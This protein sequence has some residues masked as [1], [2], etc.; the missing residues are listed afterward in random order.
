MVVLIIV[1]CNGDRLSIPNIVLLI[2]DILIWLFYILPP[3]FKYVMVLSIIGI[4]DDYLVM[5][6]LLSF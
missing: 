2:I 4:L 3:F 6:L 5:M 1:I